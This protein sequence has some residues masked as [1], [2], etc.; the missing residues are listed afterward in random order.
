MSFL[1]ITM[2]N[3]SFLVIIMFNISL[4]LKLLRDNHHLNPSIVLTAKYLP[5][6]SVLIVITK[7]SFTEFLYKEIN[8]LF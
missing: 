5:E 7:V 6:H 1:V 8:P 4:T 3:I 2:F